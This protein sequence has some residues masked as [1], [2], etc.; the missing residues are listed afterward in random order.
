VEILKLF[1]LNPRRRLFNL[2][3][4]AAILAWLARITPWLKQ[5]ARRNIVGL[6]QWGADAVAKSAVILAVEAMVMVAWGIFIAA[7][8]TG[9]TGLNI[10]EF[11]TE[12]PFSGFPAAMMVLVSA[13]FPVHFGVGLVVGYIIWKGTY[14]RA[15]LIVNRA[16]RYM[17]G[18]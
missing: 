16:V 13:A 4:M 11:L 15:V 9:M 17:F 18:S 14:A 10:H 8:T 6:G 2:K 5:F 7:F 1:S 3:N 12:N